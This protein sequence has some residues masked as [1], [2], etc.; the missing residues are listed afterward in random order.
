MPLPFRDCRSRCLKRTKIPFAGLLSYIS[1]S[2]PAPQGWGG[3]SGVHSAS[4]CR[5][6]IHAAA[7]ATMVN[8]QGAL[9]TRCEE[10]MGS[11]WSLWGF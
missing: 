8:D 9:V 11:F 2:P 4:G 7:P 5:L 6:H 3:G 10:I 1:L